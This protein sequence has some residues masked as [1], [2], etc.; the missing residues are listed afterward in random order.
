MI[1]PRRV[2]DVMARTPRTAPPS[3]TL[4]AAYELMMEGGFRHLPVVDDR[5]HVIGM[6]SD[7]DVLAAMPPPGASPELLAASAELTRRPVTAAMA[8]AVTVQEDDALEVAIELM[9]ANRVSALAV[10][11]PRDRLCGIVTL[12]DVAGALVNLL[13]TLPPSP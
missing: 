2:R 4:A 3:T 6:L 1:R 5:G 10:T 12:V 13:K 7:R 9:I 8:D 11:D